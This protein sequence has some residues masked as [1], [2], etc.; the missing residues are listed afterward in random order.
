MNGGA[1]KAGMPCS[2][3]KVGV[4]PL[5]LL[6]KPCVSVKPMLCVEPLTVVMAPN[7]RA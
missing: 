1:V 5:L 6:L 7:E 4:M 3:V 2:S